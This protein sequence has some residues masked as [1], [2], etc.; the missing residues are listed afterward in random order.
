MLVDELRQRLV[1]KV[2]QVSA[3]GDETTT[4]TVLAYIRAA[5]TA[6]AGRPGD[7]EVVL[8]DL[9]VGTRTAARI[10]GL[11]PEYVRF[12]I[13][14]G[15]LQA[16]KENGEY[17]I[18]LASAAELAAAGAGA[19]VDWE[20]GHVARIFTEMLGVSTAVWSNP[21]TEGA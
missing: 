16:T 19:T 11:H 15:R 17:R 12:L 21:K 10:L 13:R 6:L 20:S 3:E 9:T 18:A 8:Q 4:A 14:T 7:Q 2:S 1:G 5:L